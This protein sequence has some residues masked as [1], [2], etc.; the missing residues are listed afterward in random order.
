MHLVRADESASAVVGSANCTLNGFGLNVEAAI[1]LDTSQGDSVTV[2]DEI[3][4]AVDRWRELEEDGVFLIETDADIQALV[5]SLIINL[6]Q[7]AKPAVPSGTRRKKSLG[8][9]RRT[10][11]WSS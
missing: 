10:R 7:P 2:L 6:P 4:F 8:M 9:G 1:S 5:D 3:A 11:A